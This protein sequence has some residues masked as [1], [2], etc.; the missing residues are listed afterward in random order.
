MCLHHELVNGAQL[1]IV[2]CTNLL[3]FDVRHVDRASIFVVLERVRNEDTQRF[4]LSIFDC[5]KYSQTIG[6]GTSQ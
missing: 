4:E 3:R 5:V 6:S 2:I 1:R